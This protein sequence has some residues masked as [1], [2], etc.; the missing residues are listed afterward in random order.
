MLHSAPLNTFLFSYFNTEFSANEH[1]QKQTYIY[2]YG[3]FQSA[4]MYVTRGLEVTHI[5]GMQP[6]LIIKSL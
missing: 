3:S 4:S 2:N 6:L 1:K 5:N